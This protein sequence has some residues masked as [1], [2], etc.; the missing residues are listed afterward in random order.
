MNYQILSKTKLFHGTTQAEALAM[1]ECLSATSKNYRKGEVIYHAGATINHIG[2]VLMGSVNIEYDDIWGNKSILSHVEEGGIFG[3][4]YACLANEPLMINA[5]AAEN[6][7][8]LFLDVAKILQTCSSSCSHHNQLIKNLLHICAEK[9]LQL[10]RRILH[11]SSKSIRGRLMSYFSELAQR[12]QRTNFTLPFNRQQLAD[13]L[14]VDRS[15]LSN[16]L[17]KM[18]ADGIIEYDKY[19]VTLKNTA[20]L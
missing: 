19:T 9:S 6:T 12:N 18:K 2:M 5:V 17:S 4:T 3:E 8:V 1:L 10:S 16:E 20:I 13:F 7:T 14:N 15:A 11:T